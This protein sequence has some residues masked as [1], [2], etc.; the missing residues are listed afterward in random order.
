MKN[1]V[2]TRSIHTVVMAIGV[3]TLLAL[4]VMVALSWVRPLTV[5]Y[6]ALLV[7][8]VGMLMRDRVFAS[9]TR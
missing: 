4:V 5:G 6:V 3:A 8:G 1:L 2:P 7:T 9:P